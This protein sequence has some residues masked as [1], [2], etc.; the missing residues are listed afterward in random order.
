MSA[1]V[2]NVGGDG[3]GGTLPLF[4]AFDPNTVLLIEGLRLLGAVE[5]VEARLDVS[6]SLDREDPLAERDFESAF[7]SPALSLEALALLGSELFRCAVQ[8]F[9][10]TFSRLE[11]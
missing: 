3:R 8:L 7:D 6:M 4:T 11:L 2:K 9:S 10:P 5:E 1:S